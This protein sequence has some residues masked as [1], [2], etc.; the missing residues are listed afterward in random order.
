MG[1][2]ARKSPEDVRQEMLHE[3][4]TLRATVRASGEGY[5]L[6]KEGEIEALTG[7]LLTIPAGKLRTIASTW[8]R[9]S[10]ELAVKP[11]KGRLRDL[12]KIS[13]LLGDLLN[14]IIEVD[15]E[16]R[17]SQPAAAGNGEKQKN[18]PA[19]TDAHLKP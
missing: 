11:A 6:R 3:L 1:D 13:A 16:A 4:Q 5:I 12:K 2:K 10:R 9:E 17:T 14:S 15:H 18:S 19:A 7:Y 8:L